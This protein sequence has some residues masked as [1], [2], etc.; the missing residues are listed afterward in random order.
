M[1]YN[2]SDRSHAMRIAMKYEIKLTVEMNTSLLV[3]SNSLKKKESNLTEYLFSPVPEEKE[4]DL[5]E[6]CILT[7]IVKN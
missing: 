4:N 3:P 7:E 1:I 6:K 2:P 5:T